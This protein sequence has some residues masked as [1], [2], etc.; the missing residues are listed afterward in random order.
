MA[1]EYKNDIFEVIKQIDRKN[2]NYY[3]SL[4]DEQK[5]EIQPYTLMRWM[6]TVSDEQSHQKYNITINNNV[7]KYFWELSKYKDLQFKLLCTS[8]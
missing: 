8:G 3:D 5:K 2:Y 1:K 7:N 6:S 4:T